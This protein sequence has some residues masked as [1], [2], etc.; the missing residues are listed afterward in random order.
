[1]KTELKLLFASAL[2]GLA[3]A[4]GAAQAATGTTV[5]AHIDGLADAQGRTD[6]GV[7]TASVGAGSG[8]ASASGD[9][10][11]LHVIGA[12]TAH[13]IVGAP[14]SEA[15]SDFVFELQ[16]TSSLVDLTFNFKTT[17]GATRDEF[18]T[19]SSGGDFSVLLESNH[20]LSP[21]VVGNFSIIQGFGGRA[22]SGYVTTK[23][24]YYTPG[25]GSTVAWDGAS[26]GN[27]SLHSTFQG[28]IA[29]EGRL[30]MLTL[31]GGGNSSYDFLLNLASITTSGH[32]RGLSIYNPET[33]LRLAVTPLS[34]VPEPAS[35]AL[36]IAGFGMTGAM[37]RRRRNGFA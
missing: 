2:A 11:S 26:P 19:F 34:A 12:D 4:S 21:Y 14:Q 36:M 7:A 32:H 15:Q 35:W 29:N 23:A 10:T 3:A 31:F 37:V 16:G 20:G 6:G 18:S 33:G 27:Y 25:P 30:R 17:G 24:D 22:E 13:W 28:G 1:M 9:L 8:S 5:S